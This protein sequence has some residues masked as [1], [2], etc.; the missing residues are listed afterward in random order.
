[1]KTMAQKNK[2]KQD[3]QDAHTLINQLEKSQAATNLVDE[4]EQDEVNYRDTGV[5]DKEQ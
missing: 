1:M 4:I 3:I 5:R 2:K